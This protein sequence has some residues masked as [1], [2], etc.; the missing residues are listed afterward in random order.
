[1]VDSVIV[2]AKFC[3]NAK[4]IGG[5]MNDFID[6]EAFLEQ[7]SFYK[8]KGFHN[9][10]VVQAKEP[11]AQSELEAAHERI[12]ASALKTLEGCRFDEEGQ[13]YGRDFILNQFMPR[14]RKAATNKGA[15]NFVEHYVSRAQYL[16]TFYV[17]I[18]A[19]TMAVMLASGHGRRLSDGMFERIPEHDLAYGFAYGE[20]P[21]MGI[22]H[23]TDV[24]VE[25]LLKV[26]EG[27]KILFPAAGLMPALLDGA[28]L[29][30]GL[31]H[32][33][34]AYDKNQEL[35]PYKDQLFDKTGLK[36]DY[37]HGDVMDPNLFNASDMG[38]FDLA[39]CTGFFS[40]LLSEDRSAQWGCNTTRFVRSL[41]IIKDQL[42][43]GGRIVFDLQTLHP[44][45]VFD[46]VDLAW[47]REMYVVQNIDEKPASQVVVDL[48]NDAMRSVGGLE[49][50]SATTE[51][52]IFEH[53]CDTTTMTTF[54]LERIA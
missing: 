13:K 7:F 33:I 15:V 38:E 3:K 42:R 25:E 4:K 5:Y 20:P 53:Q 6:V 35:L 51:D 39:I 37:N 10:F 36:I 16:I 30:S 22:K 27:R 34:V 32:Q 54:V 2:E 19:T 14:V 29:N 31:S 47:P 28:Y 46:V 24:A 12:C 43:V 41:R 9:S 23:R 11:I 18:S 26:P 21:F 52:L 50:I 44:V 17:D 8:E 45:L 48:V 49:M 1:M 40:Y